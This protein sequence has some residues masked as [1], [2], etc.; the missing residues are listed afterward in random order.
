MGGERTGVHGDGMMSWLDA[1]H[2]P[3]APVQVNYPYPTSFLN[4]LPAHPT[5][6]AC[7]AL[8]LALSSNAS[9]VEA[10]RRAVD[11]FYNTRSMFWLAS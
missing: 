1:Q 5:R 8:L 9:A 11:V 7:G 6:S 4:P 2:I 10:L 3:Q